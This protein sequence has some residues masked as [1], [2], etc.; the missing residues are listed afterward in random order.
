MPHWA[1]HYYRLETSSS[2]VVGAWE[3]SPL[4]SVISMAIYTVLIA[5]NTAG[6]SLIAIR[7]WAALLTA[8]GHFAIGVVHVIRL[9]HPFRF[10]VI[11]HPWSR[12][13]S[14]REAA[15]VLGFGILSVWVATRVR[16]AEA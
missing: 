16:L 2:F 5:L 9:L 6:V 7:F 12:G 8:L 4:D 11:G 13:A 10:E 14:M 15:I 1:C 3:F